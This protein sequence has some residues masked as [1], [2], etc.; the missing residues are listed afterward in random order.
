MVQP[1]N[2]YYQKTFDSKHNRIC[3]IINPYYFFDHLKTQINVDLG[4][5]PESAALTEF[6][7]FLKKTLV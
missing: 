3:G 7:L 4:M 1:A 6:F 2:L 5:G